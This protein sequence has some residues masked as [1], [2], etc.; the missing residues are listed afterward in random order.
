M[1]PFVCKLSDK[2]MQASFFWAALN[3][4]QYNMVCDVRD[5]VMR[6]AIR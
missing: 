2:A 5:A 3:L 1:E 6:R 4:V